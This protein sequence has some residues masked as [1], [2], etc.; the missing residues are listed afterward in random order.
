[1]AK[2]ENDVPAPIRRVFADLE[3]ALP[4]ARVKEFPA[5]TGKLG[6]R[7][8]ESRV[9]LTYNSHKKGWLDTNARLG[10][11]LRR[12]SFSPTHN[13]PGLYW[14]AELTPEQVETIYRANRG[15]IVAAMSEFIRGS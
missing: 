8:G 12:F 1:M 2:A 7:A 14:A 10:T 4:G 6:L 9:L 3:A 5:T 13:K 15:E 11:K